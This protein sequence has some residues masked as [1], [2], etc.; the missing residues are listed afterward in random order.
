[1]IAG[2][3]AAA[4]APYARMVVILAT[5]AAFTVL[6]ALVFQHRRLKRFYGHDDS[7]DRVIHG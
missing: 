1:M 6:A 3:R 4:G 2:T 7:A 5:V